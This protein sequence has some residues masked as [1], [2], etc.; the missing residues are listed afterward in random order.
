MFTLYC[1][2]PNG[3]C[4]ERRR[5]SQATK[6]KG[7]FCSGPCM[8]MYPQDSLVTWI[9]S[10]AESSQCGFFLALAVTALFF[11]C[12]GKQVRHDILVHYTRVTSS[13]A[14]IL[15]KRKHQQKELMTISK[16]NKTLEKA[17]SHLLKHVFN[18]E[19]PFENVIRRTCGKE[20]SLE[21][22]SSEKCPFLQLQYLRP[23][24]SVAQKLLFLGLGDILNPVGDDVTRLS[25]ICFCLLHQH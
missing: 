20:I 24:P 11:A 25:H 4:L 2:W 23:G 7:Y 12:C 3:V 17:Y 19:Q 6:L 15:V 14:S 13:L 10:P 9:K 1:L 22:Q 21:A 5:L 8:A 16:I 18:S